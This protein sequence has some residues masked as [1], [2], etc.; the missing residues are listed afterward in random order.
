MRKDGSSGFSK[1]CSNC[2]KYIAASGIK[3]VVYTDDNTFGAD[4][5]LAFNRSFRGG[6]VL[7]AA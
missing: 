6:K 1:P 4:E 5:E 7:T 2:R 3:K